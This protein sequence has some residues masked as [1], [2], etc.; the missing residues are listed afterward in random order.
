M[1]S[2]E[3]MDLEDTYAAHTY[4]PIEVVIERAELAE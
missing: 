4:H 2:Q 3:Y 1:N